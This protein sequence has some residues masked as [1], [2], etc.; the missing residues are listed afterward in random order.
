M[1]FWGW[2]WNPASSTPRFRQP[3][4]CE[5]FRWPTLP[6]KHIQGRLWA[7]PQIDTLHHL[8]HLSHPLILISRKT[9]SSIWFQSVPD[10]CGFIPYT[11]GSKPWALREV[12]P[13]QRRG[14]SCL[15]GHHARHGRCAW[16]RKPSHAQGSSLVV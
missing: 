6:A 1:S 3:A 15:E 16:N 2:G 7:V 10:E 9:P 14:M 12:F 13:L 8:S 4:S 11:M 5:L